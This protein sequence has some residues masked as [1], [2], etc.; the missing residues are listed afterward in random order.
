MTNGSHWVAVFLCARYAD[1]MRKTCYSVNMKVAVFLA[2]GFEEI[3]ALTVVD[4]LRRANV[5]VA[6]VAVS[7]GSGDVV[8]GSHGIKVIADIS[9]GEYIKSLGEAL[10]DAVYAPGGMPGAAN[11]A[12]SDTLLEL[13]KRCFAAKKIVAALCAAPVVTVAKTGIL[14]DK[15]FTCYP[16]MEDDM[17]KYAGADCA[18]LTEG[19]VHVKDVPFVTDGNLVTGRG[20]GCAEQFAMELVRILCGND[21]AKKVHDLSVQR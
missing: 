5:E 12:A 2:D 9:L 20:P 1:K 14:R 19:S 15:K 4:Y 18:S 6:T 16:G 10:P 3:E 7:D 17:A 8:S 21:V 11:L 13:F